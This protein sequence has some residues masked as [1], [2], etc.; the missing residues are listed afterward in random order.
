MPSDIENAIMTVWNKIPYYNK[1]LANMIMKNGMERGEPPED[2]FNLLTLL[3]SDF[4]PNL[5]F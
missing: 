5:I 2:I 3:T 4:V 1:G